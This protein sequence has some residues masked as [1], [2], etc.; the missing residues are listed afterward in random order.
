M[1]V[2][3]IRNIESEAGI[4]ATILNHPEFTF[5]S[6]ALKP[7]HFSDTQNAYIYYAICELAKKG[8]DRIDSFNITNVLNSKEATKKQTDTITISAL[9]ELIDVSQLIARNTVVEYEMLVHNV[10]DKA[11]RRDTYKKLVECEQLCFSDKDEEIQQKIYE[12]LDKTMLEFS[13][14]TEIPQFK[15]VIRDVWARIKNKQKDSK[16]SIPFIFPTLN[17]YV[18]IEKNEFVLFSGNFKVGKSMMLMNCAI[19]FLKKDIPFLYIDSELDLEQFTTR[20]IANLCKVEF[21]RV[22]DGLYSQEECNKIEKCILWLETRTFTHIK[23]PILDFET[24]YTLVKKVKHTQGLDVLICDYVKPKRDGDAHKTYQD[25]GYLVDGIKNQICSAMHIAGL[26]AV[27]ATSTGKV[28]DSTNIERSAS[29]VVL[30]DKK[31]PEEIQRDGRECGNRK[32]IVKTNRNGRQFDDDE[33]IDI[34]FNGDLI[35]FKEAKQHTKVE[36]Y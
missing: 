29:T 2:S 30:I 3:D 24:I 18:K 16:D 10:M 13:C 6:E 5:H 20:L 34:E 14:V 11:F 9:N 35:S 8:I 19:D 27:Q 23:V 21:V 22:R 1:N 17:Q 28:A 26:G 4:I 32:L 7:N 36:P 12:T 31:T 25:L 33:Y 15:D